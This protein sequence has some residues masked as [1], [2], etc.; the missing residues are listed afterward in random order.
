VAVRAYARNRLKTDINYRVLRRLRKRVWSALR[1]RS[2]SAH[3][4]ELLGCTIDQL[5]QHLESR[6][7]P[8]MSWDNYGKWHVDHIIAC[9]TF[10]LTKEAEQR[11]CFNYTNLQPLWA[12]D[13]IRKGTKSTWSVSQ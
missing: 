7:L 4:M 2:K 10:D 5:K 13:N 9:A 3:T 6:F 8:G 12:S 1:G 11:R